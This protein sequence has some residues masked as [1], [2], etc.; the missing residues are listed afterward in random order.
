MISSS[1]FAEPLD[2][3]ENPAERNPSNDQQVF[4]AAFG[5]NTQKKTTPASMAAPPFSFQAAILFACAKYTSK[6]NDQINFK[7]FAIFDFD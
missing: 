3:Q 6:R 7:I 2:Q 5:I 1:D 4:N